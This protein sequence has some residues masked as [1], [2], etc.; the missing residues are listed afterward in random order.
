MTSQNCNIDEFGRDLTLKLQKQ[1]IYVLG[2]YF[3]RFKGMSWVDIDEMVE[4]EEEQVRIKEEQVRIKEEQVRIKEAEEKNEVERAKL[5]IVLA[6]RK[7]LHK[8]GLYELE[9]GEELD[10]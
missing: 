3:A 5:R 9:D 1:P 7:E 2:D 10:L 4:E 8:K 6:E